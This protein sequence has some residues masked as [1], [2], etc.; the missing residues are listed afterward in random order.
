MKKNVVLS[1]LLLAWETIYKKT[2][3]P[4]KSPVEMLR[5]NPDT[6]FFLT[7]LEG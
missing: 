1:L 5:K 7:P 4:F 3:K 6:L 2:F